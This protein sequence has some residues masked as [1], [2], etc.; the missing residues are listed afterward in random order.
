MSYFMFIIKLLIG[1]LSF[2]CILCSPINEDI[3]TKGGLLITNFDD[4]SGIMK[5]DVTSQ[6]SKNFKQQDTIKDL[7]LQAIEELEEELFSYSTRYREKMSKPMVQKLQNE[8]IEEEESGRKLS[9]T[10]PSSSSADFT[11]QVVFY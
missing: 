5:F 7:D 2:S 3:K 6:T 9:Q 1:F 10:C 8:E 4:S 11:S